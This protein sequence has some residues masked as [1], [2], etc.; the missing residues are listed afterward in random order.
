LNELPADA[1]PRLAARAR[2]RPDPASGKTALL[3]PETVLLLNPT[4]AA[5]VEL[6]DGRTLAEIADALAARFT[7]PREQALAE[8]AAYLGRLRDRGLVELP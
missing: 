6:C 2:L 7:V 4:S 3:A 1:R 8:S 5:I